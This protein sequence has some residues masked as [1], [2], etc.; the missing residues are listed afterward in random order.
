VV[1]MTGAGNLGANLPL[2]AQALESSFTQNLLPTG[3]TV[4]VD[5][6][7]DPTN[8]VFTSHLFTASTSTFDEVVPADLGTGFY[9]VTERFT[10]S[11]N[12]VLGSTNTTADIAFRVPAP[13]V[14]AGLPGLILGGGGLLGWWRRR[15]KS[16]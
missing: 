11:A 8:G 5:T 6:F 13:I 12:G 2:G 10:I 9:S 1:W 3:W 15:Q 7:F 14:G 4:Q 16:A